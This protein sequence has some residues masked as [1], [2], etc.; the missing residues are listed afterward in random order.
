[1]ES[2]GAMRW[3]PCVVSELIAEAQQS[4]GIARLIVAH[5][6]HWAVLVFATV[7]VSIT[8]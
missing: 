1:M 2:M 4:D 6:F 7:W 3:L 8:V 5:R